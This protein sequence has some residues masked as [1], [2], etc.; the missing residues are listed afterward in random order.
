MC[1]TMSGLLPQWGCKSKNYCFIFIQGLLP[2]N[3]QRT[4]RN[5]MNQP[6][7]K[8][9]V[10]FVTV[11]KNGKNNLQPYNHCVLGLHNFPRSAKSQ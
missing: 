7:L 1:A 9:K 10:P 5:S 8:L 2:K 11:S 6:F 4:K 3:K